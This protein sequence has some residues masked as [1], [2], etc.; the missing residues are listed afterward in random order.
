MMLLLGCSSFAEAGRLIIS[1]DKNTQSMTVSMD[2]LEEYAC[3]VSTGAAGYSTPSGTYH[4]F[5][6]EQ[7]HFSQEWDDAPMPNS[8]FFTPKGHTIHGSEHVASLGRRASH[9]CVRLDP[10]NAAT[11]F[12][13]VEEVGMPNTTVVVVAGAGEKLNRAALVR[14]RPVQMSILSMWSRRKRTTG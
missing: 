2:G 5:R 3:P 8:I 14:A 12:G 1:V 11:L 7:Y 9:G 4:P 13:L 6:T 10:A